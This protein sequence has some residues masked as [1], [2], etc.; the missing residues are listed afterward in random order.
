MSFHLTRLPV[1]LPE[2]TTPGMQQPP[3]PLPPTLERPSRGT[4]NLFSAELG[5]SVGAVDAKLTLAV[6]RYFG[7]GTN[8][9]GTPSRTPAFASTTSCRK[10]PAWRSSGRSMKAKS[11]AKAN[12]TT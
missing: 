4:P 8:E 12:P 10:I 6:N 3:Q 1:T 9:S 7:I 2:E 11:A 5:I